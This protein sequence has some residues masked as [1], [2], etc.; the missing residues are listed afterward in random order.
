MQILKTVARE[1]LGLFVAD[2]RF[3]LALVVWIAIAALIPVMLPYSPVAG[4]LSLFAGFAAIL[5]ENV[6]HVAATHHN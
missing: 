3:T 6:V 5:I 1:A 4:A 2:A